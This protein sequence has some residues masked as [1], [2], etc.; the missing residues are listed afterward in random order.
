M[1]WRAV[2]LALT[3]AATADLVSTEIALAH[4]PMVELN[5]LAQDQ[6]S[7]VVLQVGFVVL[8]TVAFNLIGRRKPLLAAMLLAFVVAM[9]LTVAALNLN[10]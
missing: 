6:W 2:A 9:K 3:L 1:R 4:P 5:P 7:R 8:G 10:W